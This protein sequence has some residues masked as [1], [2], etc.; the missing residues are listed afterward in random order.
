MKVGRGRAAGH[1][2]A[3]AGIFFGRDWC[4]SRQLW[5]G[6]RI[7]A[8]KVVGEKAEVGEQQLVWKEA[9]GRGTQSPV[10][11]SP[12]RRVSSGEPA[13]LILCFFSG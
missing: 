7:P 5:W 3:S 6:H 4:V 1:I 9:P 11:D 13:T 10:C 2:E 12:P 8:Y